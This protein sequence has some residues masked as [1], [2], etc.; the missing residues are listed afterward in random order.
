MSSQDIPGRRMA[1]RYP[2]LNERIYAPYKIAALVEV[3]AEQG[4]AP[5]D[6]LRGS[7]LS[8]D[9]LD[10]AAVLT[11]VR[12]YAVVCRNAIE[13]SSDPAT[14]FRTGSRLHLAAYGMYGYA[15]MSC[16]SLRDYFR[17]GVKYHRLATPTLTIEWREFPDRAVWTFPDAFGPNLPTSFNNSCSSSSTRSTSPICRTWPAAPARRCARASPMPRRR[18]PRSM[19]STSVAP[20]TSMPS[21][22][23]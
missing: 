20:A 6:S 9:Q 4:I 5:L 8:V 10:D 12:Q 15:L 18:M 3:L 1:A 22:A 16:L 2:L 19:P 13:L 11:S 7:G 14:P 21:S 23:N 17:L